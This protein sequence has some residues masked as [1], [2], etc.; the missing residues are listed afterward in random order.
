MLSLSQARKIDPSLKDLSDTELEEVL[1]MLYAL[2]QLAFDVWS[3]ERSVSKNPLGVL[4][5]D[6]I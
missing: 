5:K 2:G 6:P 4:T 3:K 1:K